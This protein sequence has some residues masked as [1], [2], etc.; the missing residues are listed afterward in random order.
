MGGAVSLAGMLISD[1]G[2][3]SRLA[4]RRRLETATTDLDPP[5]A[6]VDVDAWAVNAASLTARAG[7][8]PI[9]IASKSVRIRHLLTDAL[10]RPGFAGVLAFTLPEALWLAGHGVSDDIVVGYPSADR[11]ALRRLCSD[12]YL[13]RVVTLM[14]DDVAQLDLVDRLAAPRAR[15]E[16]RVCLELDAGWH[17]LGGRVRV[18]ARRS[19]LHTPPQLM[20]MARE[21]L[22]RPGFRLV[23]LMAYEAQVAGVPD[24]PPGRVARGAGVRLMQSRSMAE[25]AHR[26]AEAVAA[27]RSIADL[28]FVNGG[29]TGSVER[30]AAEACI[31][32]IAAGSGLLAPR[33]FDGYRAFDLEPAAFFALPVVRRP[34]PGVA[35]VLGGGYVASGA[36]GADRLPTPWLPAGLRFDGLE[37][38]GEVQTPLLGA[39]ADG[40][41][42]GDRVWF[43]HA[44]AGELAE[45]FPEVHLVSGGRVVDAVPTYRGEGRC[46]L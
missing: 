5:F 29:G 46:F 7:G 25:L 17:A 34:A 43:R 14:V 10:R 16:L 15:A 3:Y 36:P 37:G 32:E 42:V 20:A 11:P 33:L 26:R 2:V 30:T 41:R 45:H 28:E 31:T 44:K 1:R 6:V 40:L 8:K 24:A 9:R 4:M 21:V 19:P 22:R 38:A 23:G 18:G 39:A 12:E 13:A 27:V 35:T